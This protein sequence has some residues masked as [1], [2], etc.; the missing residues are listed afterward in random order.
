MHICIWCDVAFE[1]RT[2]L[3]YHVDQE[4]PEIRKHV[5]IKL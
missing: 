2:E 1:N 3:E 4:H 5:K